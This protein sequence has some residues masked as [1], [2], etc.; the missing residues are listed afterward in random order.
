MKQTKAPMPN[1]ERFLAICRSERPGDVPLLDWFHRSWPETTEEWVKQGAP[2]Y[3]KTGEGFNR[4]F[5]LGHLHSLQEIVAELNRADLKEDA[6]VQSAG[7][8]HSTPPVVPVYEIKIL[9]EDERHRV[10][11]GATAAQFFKT[12][13]DIIENPKR[14]E[15]GV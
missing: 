5:Q 13:Q 12:L 1:R 10:L 11:T 3:I 9:E 8:W 2:E 15:L 4:Y 7:R 6:S 14:M